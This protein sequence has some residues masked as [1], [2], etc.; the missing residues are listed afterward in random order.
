MIVGVDTLSRRMVTCHLNAR[1]SS[2]AGEIGAQDLLIFIDVC[3]YCLVVN[4]DEDF[5]CLSSECY[6]AAVICAA[7]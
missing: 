3:G 2:Q 7:D 4:I 5:T 1:W 6:F